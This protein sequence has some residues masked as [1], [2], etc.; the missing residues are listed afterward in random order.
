VLNLLFDREKVLALRGRRVLGVRIMSMRSSR[1][2][3]LYFCCIGVPSSSAGSDGEPRPSGVLTRLEGKVD[4]VSG[5]FDCT[6][7][8]PPSTLVMEERLLLRPEVSS[9]S[10]L[11]ESSDELEELGSGLARRL[12]TAWLSDCVA[13]CGGKLRD[14]EVFDVRRFESAPAEGG[15][16]ADT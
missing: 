10:S 9:S 8:S 11:A 3:P 2:G 15:D 6:A 7:G 4:S 16:D 12:A 1:L 5:L 14:F 13:M